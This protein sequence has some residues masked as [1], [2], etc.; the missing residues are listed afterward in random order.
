ML[1]LKKT[2]DLLFWGIGALLFV[3]TTA[4]TVLCCLSM[5]TM[6]EMPMPGGWTM[7]MTWMP[8]DGMLLAALSFFGMWTLMMVAMMLP[9]LLPKLYHLRDKPTFIL[10]AGI[11]YFLIWML[12]GLFIFPAGLGVSNL[13]MRSAKFSCT[14]PL[15]IAFLVIAV[16]L[17]QMTDWKNETLTVAG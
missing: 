10:M 3:G 2:S 1:S 13:M 14:E 11:G 16:G 4:L 5:E 17:F 6:P 8:V 9:T 15:L 7:T 12:A